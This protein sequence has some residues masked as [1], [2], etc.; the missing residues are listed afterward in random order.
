MYLRSFNRFVLTSLVLLGLSIYSANAAVVD[1]SA[2]VVASFGPH[3]GLFSAGDNV[4]ISYELDDGAFDSDPL[5]GDG[6]FHDGVLNLDFQFP[7]SELN[8]NFGSGTLQTFDDTD[9]PDDQ[10]FIY[11][12]DDQGGSSLLGGEVVNLLELDFDGPTSMLSSDA[13]PSNLPFASD[14]DSIIVF[15]DTD[16]GSTQVTLSADTLQIVDESVFRETRYNPPPL[17]TQGDLFSISAGVIDLDTGLEAFGAHV[18]VTNTNT[19]EV[20]NLAGDCDSIFDCD[21]FALIPYTTARALGDWTFIATLNG[22]TTSKTFPALGTGPGTGPMPVVENLTIPSNTLTP[23]FSWTT[24]ASVIAGTAN[25]G[26]VD[27]FRIRINQIGGGTVYDQRLDPGEY[28]LSEIT[29]FEIPSEVLF[30]GGFTG[31]VLIEGFDPFIR[32]RTFQ[33][34]GIAS[35]PGACGTFVTTDITL[36]S[37]MICPGR[38]FIF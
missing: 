14:V 3:A 24:P 38:A 26:N 25:G 22:D 35:G 8:F 12:S 6:V 37:D 2:T 1:F 28:P 23:T 27:R 18:T 10:V 13:V 32:S 31:Q 7:D 19:G 4:K 30:S 17:W 5:P 20:T 21:V 33:Q 15:I 11:S 16:S 36:D 9:N 34:F 29:S